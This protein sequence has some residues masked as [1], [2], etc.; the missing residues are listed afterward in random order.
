MFEHL[1]NA[2]FKSAE[3][4]DR[5]KSEF[6]EDP[7]IHP[8]FRSRNQDYKNSGYDRGHLAAAA[9]HRFSQRMMDQTFFLCN[10]AP[11]VYLLNKPNIISQLY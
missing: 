6:K 1:T 3:D 10:M 5:G 4:T 2:K 7:F 9:N 11:Q 8:F